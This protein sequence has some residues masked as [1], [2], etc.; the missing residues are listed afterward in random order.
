MQRQEPP[1]PLAAVPGAAAE[2][3]PGTDAS[4]RRPTWLAPRLGSW[5]LAVLGTSVLLFSA[6]AEEVAG[7][8]PGLPFDGSVTVWLHA[9]AQGAATGVLR[10]VTQF[11]GALVLVA[12]TLVAVLALLWRGRR[13]HAVLMATALVGGQGLNLALKAAIE[14]P[15]PQLPDPLAGAAGFAFPSGHA[16]VSLTVYG[17][18][19]F[20]AAS[21][22]TSRRRQG[23]ILASAAVL[24]LAIGFS[25][26][27][28]GV[29]YLSDVLGAFTA[30]LAWLALT[31]LVSMAH[32]P[33]ATSAGPSARL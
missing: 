22:A 24:V 29:H 25:R 12:V 26:V 3:S 27:Y 33:T 8:E 5:L 15:R 17:T 13:A 23:L 28:L 7:G 14:R 31:A 6:L 20:L 4:G 18:L 21:A 16:M 10:A 1:A 11:G 32:K 19:A 2:I 9:H 30:G